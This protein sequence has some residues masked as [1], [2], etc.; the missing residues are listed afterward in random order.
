MRWPPRLNRPYRPCVGIML[1]N[2]DRLVFV[3]KRIEGH[4]KSNA[5]QMPQGG[6][7]KGENKREAALRELKEEIGTNNVTILAQAKQDYT[8]DLPPNL[9]GRFWDGKYRG[10]RQTWFLMRF[11]GSD[12]EINI[13]TEDPE[14]SDWQWIDLPQL[15]DVVVPFKRDVYD[16][17][18]EEFRCL[19]DEMD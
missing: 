16:A 11:E 13:H 18:V 8:Y 15:H 1:V 7:D 19:I 12:D 9:M 3:A 6:V 5:W 10:Q 14:F 2:R 4:I 17:V